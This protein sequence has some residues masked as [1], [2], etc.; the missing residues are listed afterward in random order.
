MWGSDKA[1]D[2]NSHICGSRDVRGKHIDIS[3]P[4]RVRKDIPFACFTTGP[5]TINQGVGGG[6][7][8][9][10]SSLPELYAGGAKAGGRFNC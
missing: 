10:K 4:G 2:A 5:P 1:A 8:H 7:E 6:L 9:N 3:V